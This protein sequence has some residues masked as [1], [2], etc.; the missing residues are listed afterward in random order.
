[1]HSVTYFMLEGLESRF[2]NYELFMKS[3]ERLEVDEEQ[4]GGSAIR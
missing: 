1:M 3:D 4:S 2:L